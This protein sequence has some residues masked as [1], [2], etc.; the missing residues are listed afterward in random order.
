MSAHTWMGNCWKLWIN[1]L[2]VGGMALFTQNALAQLVPDLT[3]GSES[4]VVTPQII[5]GLPSEQID[6]GAIRNGNLFHSFQEFNIPDGQGAYFS[7]PSGIARILTRV[8]GGNSSQILGTLGVLGNADLFLINPNGIIFGSNARLDLNGSFVG[9][10]ANSI[11]FNDGIE[12]STTNPQTPPLLNVNIPLGLQYGA[13]PGTI[14]DRSADGT[15]EPTLQVPVGQTFALVGGDV[16][17]AG[18]TMK[19]SQ[20]RIEIGSVGDNSFVNLTPIDRGWVLNYD[21]VQNFRDISLSQAAIV[22]VGGEGG[23]DIQVQGRRLTLSDGSVIYY[24]IQSENG[25]NINVTTSESIELLG[26]LNFAFE[27]PATNEIASF[28]TGTGSTGNLR[29]QTRRLVVQEGGL[30]VNVSLSDGNAGDLTVV[31][32]ESIEV[33]GIRPDDPLNPTGI[34][35]QTFGTGKG[36]NLSIDTG[37]L[38]VRDG[39]LIASNTFGAGQAGNLT[40]K[41]AESV[42]L[43]GTNPDPTISGGIGAGVDVGAT[44]NSGSLTIETKRLTIQGGGQILTATFGDGNAGEMIINASDS[45]ELI[46]VAS[47]ADSI[48]GSSGLFASAEIDPINGAI[49]GKVGDLRINTNSLIVRDGAR[50]SADNFGTNSGGN[51][52]INVGQLIVQ[53]GGTIR[54]GAFGEGAGGTLN[55]NASDLVQ[56]TGF[57]TLGGERVNSALFVR[58]QGSGGAGSLGIQARSIQLDNF[59][60]LTADSTAGEGN[61]NIQ[62]REALI[63]RGNSDISTN[64]TGI[65]P[66]G[67]IS[68]NSDNLVALGNSDITANAENSRGGQVIINALAIFGTQFREIGSPLTSDITASS[69]L[70]AQFSGTVEIN[71]P[72]VN[73]TAGLVELDARVVDVEGL[74]ARNFCAPEQVESSSFVV[75]GRGGLPPNPNDPIT[76]EIVA[77]DWA[78]RERGSKGAGVQGSRR[79]GG[80]GVQGNSIQLREAQGWMVE[81]DG[82]VILTAEAPRV[83]PGVS[84]LIV[85]SCGSSVQR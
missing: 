4:S 10:T 67:N 82:K 19:A 12:F 39:G 18:G 62:T 63:L 76:N 28:T 65:D 64:S 24:A 20:G 31:A 6:G 57:T 14:V 7:N 74:V 58:S 25:G 16:V 60:Q 49:S 66:G 9:S 85:P 35:S 52:T 48:R 73:T 21:G 70:G 61:I 30:I 46:G 26:G 56:I 40:V 59:G 3:L 72:D 51:I 38:I 75:T 81:A 34:L 78:T 79:S 69:D 36:G 50:I 27:P 37:R 15:G 55:V 13:N 44:G 11:R 22:D 32:S 45:I 68:I 8:T 23:G 42:E 17:F 47:N 71:T 77:V 80:A 84:G 54:A 29:I 5:N 83:T 1:C 33:S 53:N 2:S 41:A 43:I